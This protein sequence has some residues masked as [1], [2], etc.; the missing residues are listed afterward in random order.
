MV[1]DGGIPSFKMLI[2]L[3]FVDNMVFIDTIK[4]VAEGKLIL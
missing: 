4:K 1:E 3:L 2:A